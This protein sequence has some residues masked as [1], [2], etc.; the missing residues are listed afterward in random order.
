MRVGR[1]AAIQALI[2]LA[3]LAAEQAGCVPPVDPSALAAVQVVSKVEP[4]K[5]CRALGPLEGKDT[6]RWAAGG[7]SYEAAL[8]DL[9]RK[10][11][12]SGGNRLVVD[13]VTSPRA[14]DY[15]PAFVIQARL[16]S[17]PV[18]GAAAAS[19]SS[20]PAASV[21]PAPARAC[22]PDCSP[23]YTCLRG[24]CVSACNPL[25]GAGE[26]CGADR[27]CRADPTVMSPAPAPAASS[28]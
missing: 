8:L 26:R 27:I 19:A 3:A 24:A 2:G 25:C 23:G 18:A 10:A 6:D 21:A 7:L 22:E 1:A 15:L 16:F 17:C 12:T 20:A 11:V 4:P 13:E 9:R 5:T 14:T 28:R